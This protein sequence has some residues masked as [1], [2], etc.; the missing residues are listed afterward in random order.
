[1]TSLLR[2]QLSVSLD[3][4]GELEGGQ[5]VLSYGL[6]QLLDGGS[7]SH[8]KERPWSLALWHNRLAPLAV[9]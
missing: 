8:L 5:K 3:P 2:L 1:M 4:Q 9:T 7:R 6:E